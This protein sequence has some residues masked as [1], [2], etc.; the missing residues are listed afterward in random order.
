MPG[1]FHREG[2]LKKVAYCT[3]MATYLLNLSCQSVQKVPASEAVP[4]EQ[5]VYAAVYPSGKVV[6]FSDSKPAVILPETRTVEGISTD[7]AR[8]SIPLDSLLYVHV[9]RHDPDKSFLAG[10]GIV[11]LAVGIVGAVVL[12]IMIAAYGE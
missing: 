12:A 11:A 4:G 7:G 2:N 3:I 10:L 9:E 5:F 6:T 8:V 1:S